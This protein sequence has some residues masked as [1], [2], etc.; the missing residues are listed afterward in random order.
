MKNGRITPLDGKYRSETQDKF[1]KNTFDNKKSVF[2]TADKMYKID[3][4][5]YEVSYSPER[6]TLIDTLKQ[7]RR[8]KMTERNANSMHGSFSN[9]MQPRTTKNVS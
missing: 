3:T 6:Q 7:K 2:D 1:T 8:M 9:R 4:S 5:R